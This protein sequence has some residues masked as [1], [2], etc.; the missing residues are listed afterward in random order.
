MLLQSKTGPISIGDALD[1]IS[2][3]GE[4]KEHVEYAGQWRTVDQ[5]H[6]LFRDLNSLDAPADKVRL[7]FWGGPPAQEQWYKASLR[8]F[9]LDKVFRFEAFETKWDM[10]I[11]FMHEV[12]GNKPV[13]VE[14]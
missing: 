1:V 14:A 9:M 13:K 7:L 6:R 5:M 4:G 12:Q 2:G 11:D 8:T 3:F 10:L